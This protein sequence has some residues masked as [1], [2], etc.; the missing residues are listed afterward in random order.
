MIWYHCTYYCCLICFRWYQFFFTLQKLRCLLTN[1]SV[2]LYLQTNSFSCYFMHFVPHWISW[3]NWT[4]KAHENWHS[5]NQKQ[6]AVFWKLLYFLNGITKHINW[7]LWTVF[8]SDA[9]NIAT[10]VIYV[11]G[12]IC[13]ANRGFETIC[14]LSKELGLCKYMYNVTH[15][16]LF[17]G[18]VSLS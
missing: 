10:G 12:W 4:K 8:S 16:W 15:I 7:I 2:V 1:D 17:H 3:V 11:F 9:G 14:T 18:I 13:T 6:F 5:T